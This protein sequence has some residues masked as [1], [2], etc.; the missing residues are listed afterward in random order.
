MASTYKKICIIHTLDDSTNFLS[1]I[2]LLA[3]DE[4]I[5]SGPEDEEVTELLEFLTKIE[6]SSLIIFLGH[7]HSSGLYCSHMD[8][9]GV[10]TMINGLVGNKVF[11]NQDVIL[12]SCNSAEFIKQL[13]TCRAVIGFGNILS[14]GKEVDN[15]AAIL[16]KR[17]NLSDLDIST[18]NN[19]YVDAMKNAI[20]L[21][22][23]NKINFKALPNWI[24]YFINKSINSVLRQ[25]EK[26]N[27]FEV[28]KL[29]FDFRNEI[30]YK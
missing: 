14:S 27:R 19:Y 3:P 13:T 29:L 6:G 23:K 5:I 11:K 21:L 20:E 9:Y 15:E 1:S 17:R 30:L 22:I 10:R 7:G 25:K 8:T 4:Y 16:G 24:S 2:G 12:L 28:A 18:F 26:Q